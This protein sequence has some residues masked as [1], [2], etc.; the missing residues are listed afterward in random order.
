MVVKIVTDSTCDLPAAVL[1][2][3]D[4]T[5]IP[6]YI[7]MEGESYLDAVDISRDDFYERL[8]DLKTP[9]TTSAP[10]TGMFVDAYTR[11][12]DAGADE[13]LSI[14]ISA[15]LSNVVNVA[16]IAAEEMGPGRVHVLDAGQLTIGTGVQVWEAARAASAGLSVAQIL[17]KLKQLGQRIHTLA[18]VDT[19]EYLKRSGRLSGFQALLGSLLR[20]KPLLTMHDDVIEMGRTRTRNRALEWLLEQV[21]ALG[22]FE[23]VVMV[24]THAQAAVEALQAQVQMLY[25]DLAIPMIVGVTPVLGAH[26]GP[27]VVGLTCIVKNLG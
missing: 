9:V 26:L 4:I 17:E 20:M 10:G 24:H 11:L 22:P 12:L 16:R 19:L 27:D 18:I 21:A 5:V 13:I 2:E 14:H 7:N 23:Q 1:A 8:R 6:C 3:Q 25:P 15:Q